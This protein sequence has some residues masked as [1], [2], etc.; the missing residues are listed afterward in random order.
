MPDRVLV[1]VDH[2]LV[3]HKLT[4]ARRHHQHARLPPALVRDRR[5]ARL[6]GHARPGAGARRG[7]DAARDRAG[8][9]GTARS[10]VFVPILRAGSACW[11]AS[12]TCSQS[13]AS[14]S[15]ASTATRRRCCRS[16]TTRRLPGDCRT[17]RSWST[18]CSP[19]ALRGRRRPRLKEQGA[20]RFACCHHR[21]AGGLPRARHPD[22]DVYSAAVD[23]QLNEIGYILPGLG[24]AGDRIWHPLAAPR[25]ARRPSGAAGCTL[26]FPCPT[27]SRSG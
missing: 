21:G 17:A 24:D 13:P 5:H 10:S 2:P 1:E 22:V 20:R 3:R 25:D 7:D 12:S 8:L 15:S 23:G 11:T 14:A 19:P 26:P 4:A 9:A 27:S 6:R 16:T 18:R